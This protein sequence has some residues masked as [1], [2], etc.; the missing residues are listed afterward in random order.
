MIPEGVSKG[1][2]AFTPNKKLSGEGKFYCWNTDARARLGTPVSLLGPVSSMIGCSNG[3]GIF[4]VLGKL[5]DLGGRLSNSYLALV[6]PRKDA[7]DP[8]G[9]YIEQKTVKGNPR[10]AY[11]DCGESRAFS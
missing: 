2:L 9:Y 3:S 10:G 11:L 8:A 5:E 6:V 1:A 4:P 7:E